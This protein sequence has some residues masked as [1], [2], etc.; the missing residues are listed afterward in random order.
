MGF[1]RLG[2]QFTDRRKNS[3]VQSLSGRQVRRLALTGS[4]LVQF[5]LPALNF[6]VSLFTQCMSTLGLRHLDDFT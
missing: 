5:L 2:V 1:L 4:A 6:Q 3:A